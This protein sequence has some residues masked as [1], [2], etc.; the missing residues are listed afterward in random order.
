LRPILVYTGLYA[1][2]CINNLFEYITWK[3]LSEFA[4][5]ESEDKG[6]TVQTDRY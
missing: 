3:L 5:K 6:A 1:L 2:F 4:F